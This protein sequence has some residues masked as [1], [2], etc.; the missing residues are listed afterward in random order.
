MTRQAPSEFN[1]A[2]TGFM[3]VFVPPRF[4]GSSKV[5]SN[6]RDLQF[7]FNPPNAVVSALNTSIAIKISSSLIRLQI[8]VSGATTKL[9]ALTLLV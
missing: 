8:I 1:N 5:N 2:S 6:S 3:P 7:T 4:F 9:A